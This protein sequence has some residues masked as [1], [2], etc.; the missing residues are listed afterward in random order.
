MAFYDAMAETATRLLTKYGKVVTMERKTSTFNAIT[1]KDTVASLATFSPLGVETPIN[2]RLIDGTRVRVG[3]RFLI[4]DT[5]TGYVPDMADKLY[6]SAG[7][8]SSIVAIET[9]SP[10][11]TPVAYKL[12]VRK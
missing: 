5:S 4:L 7:V 1:G 11:G 8:V 6:D 9:I 10:A 12:Q 3:D 2:A